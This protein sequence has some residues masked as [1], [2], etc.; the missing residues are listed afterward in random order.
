MDEAGGLRE[1]WRDLAGAVP[2]VDAVQSAEEFV[3]VSETLATVAGVEVGALVGEHWRVPFD[4]AERER[5]EAG[6]ERARTDGRWCGE[7]RTGGRDGT[8]VELTLSRTASGALVWAVDG[9][10]SEPDGGSDRSTGTPPEAAPSTGSTPDQDRSERIAR[11]GNQSA[12]AELSP[13]PDFARSLLDTLDDGVYALDEDHRLTFVNDG[14]CELAGRS[15]DDLLGRNVLELFPDEDEVELAAEIREQVVAG[16]DDSGV[17]E[18]TLSTP[19]GERAVESHFHLYPEPEDGK[20]R[21]SVGVLRDMTARETRE[22]RLRA[23]RQFNEELVENAPFGMFRLDEDLRITYENPRAEEI[24]GLPDG[25]ETSD[26]LGVDI[27]ELPPIVETGQAKTFSRLQ[28]GETIEFEFPFESIYGKEAYFTGRA[29][30]LYRDGEFDGA[31]LMA[32]DISER[33]QY[34]R[35]LERQRDELATLNR[36]NELLLETARELIQTSSRDAIERTVCER[37]AASDLYQFAWVGEQELDDD[38]IVARTSAGEG[39]GYLDAVTITGDD[40]T[41]GRGP[42]GTALRSG[43]V[44]VVNVDDDSFAPWRDAAHERG[45]ESIAAVP[46][47]HGQTVY[48]VLVLYA[49]RENAFSEREQA[50]FDVLGR[51]VGFVIH[52]TRSRELLF[53]DS[54]VDLEFRIDAADADAVS[55]E[56][57]RTLGCELELEGHVAAG[58]NWVLYLDVDGAAPAVVAE[59][60][61][62]NEAVART[63]VVTPGEKRGRVEAVVTESSLLHTVTAV[64]ATVRTASVDA[65]G[66]HLIVEAPADADLESVVDHIQSAYSGADFVAHREHDR[67]VTTVGRPGGILDDLTDRQREALEAAYRAGYFDWPRE[68]TAE[69]VAESLDLSPPTL[70]GHLRKAE[71]AILSA[72]LD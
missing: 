58:D 17:L 62:A 38:R 39:A 5:I 67:E 64:G 70:H 22:E 3:Y 27:R 53:A 28:D 13:D 57:A 29:V 1:G 8:R 10:D 23:A 9:Y 47:R 71:A 68:S 4:P 37:L 6:I 2:A 51:T 24:I 45:F 40:S 14:F 35:E 52:A 66:A 41:T 54:V 16:D 21:G 49:T 32:T 69:V 61:G 72:L 34:E 33:R 25:E 50:G 30:P 44:Q 48:G 56:A 43:E 46:L 26:A 60:V 19:T 20:F 11:G 65:D 36:I 63:R 31:V 42:A 12:G 15:R 59:T 7:A 18:G 55:V